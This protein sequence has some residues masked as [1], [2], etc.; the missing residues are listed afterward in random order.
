MIK[1]G[2]ERIALQGR[3]W[4]QG[5]IK[6]QNRGTDE[7]DLRP[8]SGY[9]HIYAK[10]VSGTTKLYYRDDANTEKEIATV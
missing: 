4:L 5:Y 1:A 8:D 2:I 10:T 6:L 3:I 9:V 7:T